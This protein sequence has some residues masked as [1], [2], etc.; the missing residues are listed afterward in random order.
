[1]TKLL[2]LTSLLIMPR[3]RK[4]KMAGETADPGCDDV[5]SAM[6]QDEQSEASSLLISPSESGFK[7]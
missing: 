2:A 4:R 5:A 3:R 6:E 7:P 1:M